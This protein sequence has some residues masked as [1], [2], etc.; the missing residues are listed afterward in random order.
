MLSCPYIALEVVEDRATYLNREA[1]PVIRAVLKGK[2]RGGGERPTFLRLRIQLDVTEPRG[3]NNRGGWQFPN[4]VK[5]VMPP[6]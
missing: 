4:T 1:T 5:S 3:N 6:W 2:S